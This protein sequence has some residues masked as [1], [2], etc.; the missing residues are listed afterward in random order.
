M[1]II[2]AKKL[3]ELDTNELISLLM[4]MQMEDR[5]AFLKLKELLDDIV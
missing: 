5:D 4:K 2:L 1:E 3:Q